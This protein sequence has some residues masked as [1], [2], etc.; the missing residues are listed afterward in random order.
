MRYFLVALFLCCLIGCGK[1]PEEEVK[2]EA[3]KIRIHQAAEAMV[4]KEEAE[5]NRTRMG[6]EGE[7]CRAVMKS[8]VKKAKEAVKEEIDKLK[9]KAKAEEAK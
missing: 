5:A 8:D 9:G 2:A 4:Q 3:E 7:A 6:A 1:S